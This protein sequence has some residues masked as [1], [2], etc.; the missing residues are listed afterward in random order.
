M[1]TIANLF[2]CWVNAFF[3]DH[4]SKP[5][6]ALGPTES[7]P[8][9]AESVADSDHERASAV[10]TSRQPSR[11]NGSIG[12][13][14]PSSSQC[15]RLAL[16]TAPPPLKATKDAP[17]EPGLLRR[18]RRLQNMRSSTGYSSDTS[19]ETPILSKPSFHRRPAH[20]HQ[21]ACV[22]P[23]PAKRKPAAPIS[24][25]TS[26]TSEPGQ[27]GET[28]SRRSDRP[29]TVLEKSTQCAAP[30]PKDIS[31]SKASE[32]KGTRSHWHTRSASMSVKAKQRPTRVSE[33]STNVS[34]PEGTLSCQH[35]RPTPASPKSIKR[36][37]PST[38]TSETSG[39]TT[40]NSAQEPPAPT[41]EPRRSPRK[42]T[43]HNN[44]SKPRSR[45]P[46][47][48]YR[49]DP[50][51]LNPAQIT[52]PIHLPCPGEP[53]S[54]RRINSAASLADY[55]PE[56]QPKPPTPAD[57]PAPVRI[58]PLPAR[59][60]PTSPTLPHLRHEIAALDLR[61]TQQIFLVENVAAVLVRRRVQYT[62]E[63]GTEWAVG[64]VEKLAAEWEAS[65]QEGRKRFLGGLAELG[66]VPGEV[67]EDEVAGVVRR[68]GM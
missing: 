31:A 57:S 4:S 26:E 41:P 8:T 44:P 60:V 58:P 1:S 11:P 65:Y 46:L 61:F 48:I 52:F 50:S 20:S 55:L 66:L 43:K 42:R 40:I 51:T 63:A 17:R 59:P 54:Y 34:E 33:D 29:S 45:T 2:K 13:I 32:K 18:S 38:S 16:S 14:T 64:E 9:H 67:R 36:P 19:D 24:E 39:L 22:D 56:P 47:N 35:T 25:D 30:V 7:S 27:P 10:D 3:C 5:P 49:G 28:C 53:G 12:T 6:N 23:V 37:A 62:G 21:R 68:A 15:S